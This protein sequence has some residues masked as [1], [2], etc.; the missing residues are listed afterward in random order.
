VTTALRERLKCLDS[1]AISDALDSLGLPAAVIGLVPLTVA[2]RIAGMVVTV[3]LTTGLPPPGSARH[4]GTAAIE[5]AQPGDV[6]VLEHAPHA[7]CAGWGGVLSA[8][9]RVRGV[10][11]IVIDGPARDI[12]EARALDFPVYGRAPIAR[13][14]RGRA[15]EE[16]YDCP[17]TIGG[18]A[19][20]PGDYVVADSSGVAF[21]PRDHLADVVR[22]AERIAERERL[23][24]EALRQGDPITDVVGRDYEEM[25]DRLD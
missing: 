5:A 7:P 15:F 8:G 23:M 3:K 17:I 18:V 16:A 19:V 25:L 21:V 9:A 4:L 11:G 22:R 1:C 12:D 20:H 10:A 14:A 13:T 24:V 6:I 2:E